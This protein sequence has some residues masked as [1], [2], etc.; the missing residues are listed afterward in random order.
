MG[1]VPLFD[2]QVC[3][4][5]YIAVDWIVE[6]CCY[7]PGDLQGESPVEIDDEIFDFIVDAYELDPVTG[8]KVRDESV[9]SRPKGRAKTEVAGWLVCFE[10]FGPARFDRWDEQGQPV[11]KPVTSPLIKCLAT[12]E[13]QATAA[14]SVVA[15]IVNDWGKEHRPEVYGDS[16]GVRQY[17][18]ATAIYL[19][20]GGEIRASTSGS[21]SKDGGKETFVVADET[22]LYVLREL[23]AMY[24]TIRRNLGKRKLAEPWLLQTS[25][26]YRPGEESIFEETLTAWRKGELSPRVYVNH[27]E[28]KGKV[29]I[30]DAEHTLKQLRAV[31]GPASEWMDLDRIYREMLDPRSCPDEATAARYFLNR[32]MSGQDAWIAKA[33]HER[34]TKH[35]VVEPG[36]AIA[37]GFDGS[38]NDDTTVL[39]GCRMSDGFLFKIGAW[40][41][42]DGAAGEGWQV[43]RLEVIAAIDEAFER[44]T[45]SRLYAD[46]HEWRSDIELL[47]EKHGEDRVIPWA[48][49]RYTAM[50][51]ALDRLHTGLMTGEIWHDDDPLAAEHYGNV[52]VARRGQ[53]RLVRKETP[54]SAR[55]IDSVVGDALALEA[56]A[57][58]IAA[59]WTA[60]PSET[61]FRL[62][63]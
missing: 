4:L 25:T 30:A 43:P 29:D 61:Y 48:T 44:Y 58:A 35:E 2:G 19:P 40:P 8:R 7:G 36:E 17:Q 38:L 21:A 37:M 12:E 41:K 3:S 34:Q 15:Y 57:D 33:V 32:P 54:N 1:F 56:R 23:K 42:P 18:S 46:P 59:G 5:G 31:Y 10:A 52:M 6:N 49:S 13:S 51:A 16:S 39:R 9:L 47:A 28:A 53:M 50:H 11:G 62:P 22:H 63:R 26:A 24:G 60:E 27:R 55:K 45:V 14:F 20:H